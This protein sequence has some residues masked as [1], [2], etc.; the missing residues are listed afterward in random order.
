MKRVLAGLVT[1]ALLSIISLL[2]PAQGQSAAATAD[3]KRPFSYSVSDEV[4]LKG[5]VSS[6]LTKHEPGMIM[7]AHLMV[8]T[9]AG[10]VDAS[11][12][13]FGLKVKGVVAAS[14]GDPIEM[15]GIMK[16]MKNKPVFLVRLVKVG[17]QTYTIR[18]E[19]GFPVGPAA[20]DRSSRNTA[21][22]GGAL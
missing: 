16:T 5:T 3:S 12:G 13:A 18:N 6:V 9:S 19:H 17:N 15:T 1:M 2:P 22:N 20:G 7:G 21:E 8:N 11:L 14:P 10:M 4:T